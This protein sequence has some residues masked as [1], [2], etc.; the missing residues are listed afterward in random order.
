MSSAPRA[1]EADIQLGAVAGAAH[2]H[3]RP[4]VAGQQPGQPEGR[5][6]LAGEAVERRPCRSG[7]VPAGEIEGE[8]ERRHLNRP[9]G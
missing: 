2:P 3:A 5:E 1:G 8:T 4:G 7:A 9:G 6:E